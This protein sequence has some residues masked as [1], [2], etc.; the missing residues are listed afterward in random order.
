MT[1]DDGNDD[2]TDGSGDGLWLMGMERGGLA[3]GRRIK[4][5]GFK[6]Q[7]A[8][9]TSAKTGESKSQLETINSY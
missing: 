2:G 1:A 7:P 9:T 4:V 3:V 6:G 5:R 8:L